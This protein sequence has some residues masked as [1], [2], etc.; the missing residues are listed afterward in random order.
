MLFGLRRLHI[1]SNCHFLVF[2]YSTRTDIIIVALMYL[3]M[4]VVRKYESTSV[5]SSSSSSTFE[6]TFVVI[7]PIK[8]TSL[9]SEYY[10]L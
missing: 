9:I 2:T 5:H 10:A 7:L 8:Y 3:R 4:Y 1:V 6:G